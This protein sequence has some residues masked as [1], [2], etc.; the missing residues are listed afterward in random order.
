MVLGVHGHKIP[1]VEGVLAPWPWG[2]QH[3]LTWLC[4]FFLSP[5]PP[6]WFLDSVTEQ[7]QTMPFLPEFNGFS[8]LELS[9]LQTFVPDMQ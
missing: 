9:G 7:D 8:Y 2:W 1:C 3:R 4:L 5:S 6:L